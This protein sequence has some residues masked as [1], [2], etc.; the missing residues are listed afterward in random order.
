M[1][2][3]WMPKHRFIVMERKKYSL[4]RKDWCHLLVSVQFSLFNSLSLVLF[5]CGFDRQEWGTNKILLALFPLFMTLFVCVWM[6]IFAKESYLSVVWVVDSSIIINI[7]FLA[8]M[9]Q[10][11]GHKLVFMN[12]SG[13]CFMIW[14]KIYVSTVVRWILRSCP[15]SKSMLLRKKR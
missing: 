12:V 7:F 9:W 4:N 14:L 1:G 15:K 5:L 10:L 8:E 6:S 13:V 11:N 2:Q 3:Q